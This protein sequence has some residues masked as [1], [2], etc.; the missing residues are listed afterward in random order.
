MVRSHVEEWAGKTDRCEILAV[1]LESYLPVLS[2][3][4]LNYGKGIMMSQ[5]HWKDEPEIRK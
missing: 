2:L 4:Q 3:S 1:P 5:H